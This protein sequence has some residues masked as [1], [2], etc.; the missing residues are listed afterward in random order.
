MQAEI[1]KALHTPNLK[2]LLL[3]LG[4]TTV[5]STPA[6]FVAHIKS[7]RDGYVEVARKANIV[8]K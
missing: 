6:E 1:A 3:N 2:E 7:E 5:G 8:L 4:Y